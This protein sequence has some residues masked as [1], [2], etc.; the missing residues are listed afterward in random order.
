MWANVTSL[1]EMNGGFWKYFLLATLLLTAG[2]LWLGRAKTAADAKTFPQVTVGYLFSEFRSRAMFGS[3][4]RFMRFMSLTVIAWLWWNMLVA[5]ALYGNHNA[6]AYLKGAFRDFACV[7]RESCPEPRPPVEVTDDDDDVNKGTEFPLAV[8]FVITATSLEKSQER[9]FLF[10]SGKDEDTIDQSLS[11]DAWYNVVRDPRWVVVRKPVDKE[12]QHA[13]FASGSPFPVFSAHDVPLRVLQNKERLID[14]GFAHNKPLEAASALG[15]HK[16]LVINSS[17]LETAGAGRC[18]LATLNIGELACNLPK[19][20]PYLWERSQV[21][22]LLST[23]SMLV[24]SIYPTAPDGYWPSLTD[25]R[26]ASVQELLKQAA[27]DQQQ[28][29]RVGVIEGWGAPE[30]STTGFLGYDADQV[31]TAI[32]QAEQAQTR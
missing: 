14:G 7:V 9:Y 12:L 10:V 6:R 25:F 23:R 21:E 2:Y 1:L 16:V 17:P 13:A 19:L 26:R 31:R 11:D 24:A 8:P 30:F 28:E 4:K 22:D 3:E 27:N 5:P 29:L 32:E 20:L 15:A 18:T